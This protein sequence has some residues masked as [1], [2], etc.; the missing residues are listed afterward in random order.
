MTKTKMVVFT[1]SVS[2]SI[3]NRLISKFLDCPDKT[4]FADS[5]TTTGIEEV[6]DLTS[7]T[8]EQI[9][10][11]VSVTTN[12]VGQRIT[13]PLNPGAK[14]KVYLLVKWVTTRCQEL[15]APML[16]DDWNK[17]LVNNFNE[18]RIS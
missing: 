7:M 1:R 15:D 9:N 17:L 4:I 10:G 18:F 6:E 3:R 16:V 8:E 5:L 12:K 14:Q 11:L 2:H 13:V